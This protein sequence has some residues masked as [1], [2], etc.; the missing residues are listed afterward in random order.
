MDMMSPLELL[1]VNTSPAL[2]STTMSLPDAM[3]PKAA[4]ATWTAQKAMHREVNN[5]HIV[6]LCGRHDD[7]EIVYL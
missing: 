2:V 1:T 5:G 4:Y 3:N 7:E 6:T